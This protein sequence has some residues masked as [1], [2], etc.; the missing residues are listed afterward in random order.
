MATFNVPTRRYRRIG[1]VA[2]LLG[3]RTSVLRFWE[4]R[5]DQMRRDLIRI[6]DELQALLDTIRQH[7]S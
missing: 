6:R 3:V 1:E 2:K 5:Q 7:R 4:S